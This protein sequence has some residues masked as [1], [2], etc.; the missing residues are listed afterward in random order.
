MFCFMP[1]SVPSPMVG[2][3]CRTAGGQLHGLRG[4]TPRALTWAYPMCTSLVTAPTP[5]PKVGAEPGEFLWHLLPTLATTAGEGVTDHSGG[6]EA[7]RL[8]RNGQEEVSGS[9]LLNSQ[10]RVLG[11]RRLMGVVPKQL[12][13]VCRW[14]GDSQC[15]ASVGGEG[16]ASVQ[17]L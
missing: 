11:E 6:S 15:A 10:L 3:P 14:R 16:R 4:S 13:P 7:L 12:E 17:P 9:C 1:W 8:G 5:L 2:N